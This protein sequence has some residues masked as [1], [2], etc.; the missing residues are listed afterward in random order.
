MPKDPTPPSPYDPENVKARWWREARGLTRNDLAQLTGFSES[1][2]R[3]F[4]AGYQNT[5]DRPITDEAWQ[6]YRQAC[7][8]VAV[9]VSFSW[10]AARLTLP[11]GAEVVLDTRDLVEPFRDAPEAD[12]S[13][14]R[15]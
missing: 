10:L 9:G 8:S 6:R 14:D 7:A 11:H 12:G 5:P 13:S 2:I 3:N 15:P 1:S 4:E